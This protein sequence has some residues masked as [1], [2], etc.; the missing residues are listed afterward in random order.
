MS[1]RLYREV[2]EI[3]EGARWGLP[4]RVRLKCGHERRTHRRGMGRARCKQCEDAGLTYAQ[5]RREH[6]AHRCADACP[7]CRGEV[8]P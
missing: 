2:V 1:K 4:I 6:D 3:I 8:A 7:F 5:V